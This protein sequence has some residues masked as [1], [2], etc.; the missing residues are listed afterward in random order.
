MLNSKDKGEA[1]MVVESLFCY[2][3]RSKLSRG[4]IN[5]P[6]EEINWL[7]QDCLSTPTALSA[8]QSDPIYQ[9]YLCGSQYI[10][11]VGY[12][13]LSYDRAL[14]QESEDDDDD[15]DLEAAAAAIANM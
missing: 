11:G 15:E 7:V 12:V 9:K 2:F 4:R 14:E 13:I 8:S 5:M 10:A 6:P 1:Q 3:F